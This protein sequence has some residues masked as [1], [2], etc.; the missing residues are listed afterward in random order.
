MGLIP[1]KYKESND[2]L[3][4]IVNYV[5]QGV[6]ISKDQNITRIG[7]QI[8]NKVGRYDKETKKYKPFIEE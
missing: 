3:G 1:Q 7:Q 8:L 5:F 4:A 2:K 6:N